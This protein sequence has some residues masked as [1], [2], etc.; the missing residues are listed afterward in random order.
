MFREVKLVIDPLYL[1]LV[2][3][4]KEDELNK[5]LRKDAR[6]IREHS[7]TQPTINVPCVGQV[8]AVQ[9]VIF[10][11]AC[12]KPNDNSSGE[13]RAGEREH[14]N[15][16][17]SGNVADMNCRQDEVKASTDP[18]VRPK[19]RVSGDRS[20]RQVRHDEGSQVD[21][22]HLH[23]EDNRSDSE[24]MST[25]EGDTDTRNEH[26]SDQTSR[27][28]QKSTRIMAASLDNQSNSDGE[29]NHDYRKTSGKSDKNVPTNHGDGSNADGTKRLRVSS[30]SSTSSDEPPSCGPFSV[31]TLL[32]QYLEEKHNSDMKKLYRKYGIKTVCKPNTK[33]WGQGDVT[34]VCDD[35]VATSRSSEEMQQAGDEF[36][37]LYQSC[38]QSVIISNPIA[39]NG[40]GPQK[41]NE[42]SSIIWT[43]QPSVMVEDSMDDEVTFVGKESEVNDAIRIFRK[44]T[45]LEPKSRKLKHASQP[46]SSAGPS[47]RKDSDHN[48]SQ[49]QTADWKPVPR[50]TSDKVLKTDEGVTVIARKDDITTQVVDVIVNASNEYLSHTGGVAEAL[51]H[52][53]GQ[54]LQDECTEIKRKHPGSL[55]V[56]ECVSTKGYRLSCNFVIHA[57]GPSKSAYDENKFFSKLQETF[58]NSF[59]LANDR[60]AKSIAL[61]LI[62][63]GIYGGSKDTCAK[64]LVSA[65]KQYSKMEKNNTIETIVLVNRD[66]KA[67]D[68]ILTQLNW[69]RSGE[70]EEGMEVSSAS[71]TQRQQTPANTLF[72]KE[73]VQKGANATAID[74]VDEKPKGNHKSVDMANDNMNKRFILY[75]TH[76]IQIIGEQQDILETAIGLDGIIVPTDRNL[77]NIKPIASCVARAAGSRFASACTDIHRT[78]TNGFGLQQGDTVHTHGF[79]LDCKELI[80]AVV[81]DERSYRGRHQDFFDASRDTVFKSLRYADAT[82]KLQTIALPLFTADSDLKELCSAAFARAFH[83]FID[84]GPKNIRRILIVNED[85][86]SS[87]ALQVAFDDEFSVVKGHQPVGAY[88]GFAG[89]GATRFPNDGHQTP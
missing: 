35:K 66:D 68:A 7:Q 33:Q 86:E 71:D 43:E 50:K 79:N 26:A 85:A 34:I 87:M 57:I 64:A 20:S 18:A 63:S 69:L 8:Q 4:D 89:S 45:G 11:I 80:L 56:A 29:S 73:T 52:A 76:D 65:I 81:P 1:C 82:R 5:L 46:V 74:L 62:S 31:S 25:D 59:K 58:L 30:Q 19:T 21:T 70:D 78:Q 16:H 36:V 28:K 39:C 37:A 22:N 72:G 53:A 17:P 13:E 60:C 41:I 40:V 84:F 2:P 14:E 77:Y 10:R 24:W 42:A 3:R 51:L 38:Y 88:G 23:P 49:S 44:V 75:E 9:D 15:G 27:R 6:A 54:G 32:L 61:P 83:Q 67:N 55:K 12:L 48:R 47:Y